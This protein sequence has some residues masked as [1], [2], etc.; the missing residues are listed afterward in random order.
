VRMSLSDA[1]ASVE[2]LAAAAGIELLP[3]AAD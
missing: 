3:D 2:T 1:L